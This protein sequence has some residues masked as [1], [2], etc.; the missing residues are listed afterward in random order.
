MSTISSKPFTPTSLAPPAVLP[1]EDGEH[2]SVDELIRRWEALPEEWREKHKRIELINGVVRMAPISGGFHAGPDADFGVFLGMYRWATPGLIGGG[3]TSIILDTDYMPEPDA[4]L[5]IDPKFGGRIKFDEGGFIH[6]CPELLAEM[7][8]SSVSFDMH[9]KKELYR[10]FDVKEYVVWRVKEK[11][12]DWFKLQGGDF[13][14]L[15][16]VDGAYKSEVFPGLWL[17][18]AALIAGDFAQVNQVLQQGL[19]SFEHVAFVEQ[20]RKHQSF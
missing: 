11:A 1:L 12:I 13:E 4:Y 7:S 18:P 14:P 9:A 5:A 16:L 20:L 19:A 6:G 3:A 2:M 17:A 15:P 8:S 10:K